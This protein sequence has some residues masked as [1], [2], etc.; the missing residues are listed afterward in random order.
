MDDEALHLG[1]LSRLQ[2]L[3]SVPLKILTLDEEL[4]QIATNSKI[5][6]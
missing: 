6:E 2:G 4:S 3:V 1:T 5:A